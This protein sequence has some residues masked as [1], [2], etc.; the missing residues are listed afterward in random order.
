MSSPVPRLVGE[1]MAPLPLGALVGAVYSPRAGFELEWS[2]FVEGR[3]QAALVVR[4]GRGGWIAM[5]TR[6]AMG[7]PSSEDLALAIGLSADIERAA[8][9]ALRS[10]G[11]ECRAYVHCAPESGSYTPGRVLTPEEGVGFLLSAISKVRDLRGGARHGP[12]ESASVSRV[13]TSDGG[14][15]R[16]EVEYVLGLSPV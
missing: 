3:D 15:D 7:N 14:P 1:G 16:T 6:V 8:V 10:L 5:D 4:L 9:E 12:G 2:Q 13:P 11:V